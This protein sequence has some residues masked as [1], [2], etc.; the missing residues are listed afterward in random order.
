MKIDAPDDDRLVARLLREID[1]T[2][3]NPS[4]SGGHPDEEILALFALGELRGSE[5][6]DLIRHLADCAACRQVASAVVSWPAISESRDKPRSAR[7]LWKNKPR[8]AWVG[9]AS[10]ALVLIAVGML[11]R[12][13]ESGRGGVTEGAVYAQ[14]AGLL[15]RGQFDRVR[16]VVAEAAQ[17]GIE[18]DRLRLVDSQALRRIPA[19]LA[20]A[21]AGR[22]TD[23]GFELGGVVARGPA[24]DRSASQTE[25]ALNV[26]VQSQSDDETIALNRG[27]AFLTL[28]RPREALTEFH[29]VAERSP[30]STLASLGEGLAFFAIGDY[31]AAEKAFRT[32]LQLD[33]NQPAARINLAMALAEEGKIADALATWEEILAQPNALTDADRRAIQSEVEELRRAMERPSSPGSRQSGKKGQGE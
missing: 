5:R 24:P 27:H 2:T 19:T 3:E 26:L 31:P 10:A 14:A 25:Q 9:L 23:F 32:C 4:S 8:L 18:S 33:S 20:L 11:I 28:H 6:A 16:A 15:Q 12:F 21:Y 7:S 1:R 29:T 13:K 22:L 30:N 17:R